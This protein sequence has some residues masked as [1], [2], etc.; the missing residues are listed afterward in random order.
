MWEPRPLTPL[1]A[2]TA[3]YRDSFTYTLLTLLSPVIFYVPYTLL[4]IS[5]LLRLN[6]AYVIIS[7]WLP[8][9][10]CGRLLLPGLCEQFIELCLKLRHTKFAWINPLRTEFLVNNIKIQFVSHRKYI[11]SSL[12]SSTGLGKQSLFTVRTI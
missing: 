5:R 11:T 9:W 10:S 4:S 6:A 3:C 1:W 2:F 7:F 8:R 12:Q